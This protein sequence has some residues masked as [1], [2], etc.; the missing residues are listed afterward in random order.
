ME[1]C[2]IN[3]DPKALDTSEADWSSMGLKA[4]CAQVLAVNSTGIT[5]LPAM[6]F[7]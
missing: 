6:F 7:D 5:K 4:N 1:V 2:F 3:V